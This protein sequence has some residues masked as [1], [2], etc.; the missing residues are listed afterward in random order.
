MLKHKELMLGFAVSFISVWSTQLSHELYEVDN[1]PCRSVTVTWEIRSPS[2][3]P[4]ENITGKVSVIFDS[5]SVEVELPLKRID[6]AACTRIF[7]SFQHEARIVRL[8]F[9]ALL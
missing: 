2:T 5:N 9:G 6:D 8:L 3:M 4:D 7:S 1:A